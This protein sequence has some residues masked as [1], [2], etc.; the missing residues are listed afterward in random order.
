MN[1]PL[2][3]FISIAKIFDR[4][5]AKSKVVY[6]GIFHSSLIKLLVV[7]ELRK[8]NIF[9]ESFNTSSH[10]HINVAPTP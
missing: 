2:Y 8:K 9:W 6:T 5:Q 7:E 10:L 4:V 1:L 3:L